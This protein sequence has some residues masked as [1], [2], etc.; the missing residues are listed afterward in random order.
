MLA[1]NCAH[2]FDVLHRDGLAAAG[3]V[4][5]GQHD[6]RHAG[7]FVPALWIKSFERGNVHVALEGMLQAGLAALG[8]DEID[9]LGADELHVGAGGVEVRVVGDDIAFLAH[10]AEENALG[11]AAL[12]GRDDVLVAEDILNGSAELLE[13]AAA[14]ITLVAFHHGGPLVGGHGASAGIGEQ[15]DEDIVGGQKK[16]V[17]VRGA[18][19]LLALRA[20]RP[21]NGLDALDA[22]GFDDGA[23]H[24]GFSFLPHTFR[25][26]M[27]VTWITWRRELIFVPHTLC[28]THLA[29]QRSALAAK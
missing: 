21:V 27:S 5:H 8:D 6:Q 28:C 9:R 24:V 16:E 23:G 25:W 7:F 29:V 2:G 18:E 10:H 11:G 19:Q 13:A 14:G 17:V 22:K 1:A 3:V 12:V 26:G 15:V 20:G 4:G